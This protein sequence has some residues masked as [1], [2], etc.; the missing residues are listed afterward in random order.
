[1]LHDKESAG[2]RMSSPTTPTLTSTT[3]DQTTSLDPRRRRKTVS[4][5]QPST[6][7]SQSH[8]IVESAH[9]SRRSTMDLPSRTRYPAWVHQIEPAS[10]AVGSD[11]P[12]GHYLIKSKSSGRLRSAALERRLTISG[13]PHP[14]DTGKAGALTFAGTTPSTAPLP[15][16]SLSPSRSIPPTSSPSSPSRLHQPGSLSPIPRLP[17]SRFSFEVQSPLRKI[18]LTSHLK[19]ASID[20]STP[21]PES[22]RSPRHS[23]LYNGHRRSVPDFHSSHLDTESVSDPPVVSSAATATGQGGSSA[24]LNGGSTLSVQSPN[25]PKRRKST[26]Y[27]QQSPPDVKRRM[28][29][30]TATF[31]QGR[32]YADENGAA[33]KT[34]ESRSRNDDIFLNIARSDSSRRESLGRSELRRSR[35]RMSGTGFRSSTSRVSSDLT[36]SPEQLSRS[37]TFESPLHSNSQNGFPSTR[38]SSLPYSYSASAHPLD[39]S[40]RSPQSNF[41]SSSHSTVGLPRSRLSRTN[42]ED[43]P[44]SER[45]ASLHDSR[46]FR[47]S[48][49]STIRSSRQASAS[50]VTEKPRYESRQD[51][52]ESTLSTTAPSTVWDELEDLKSRI[53]KLELTGKLP[54]SSQEAMLSSGDRP[55][56]ATTTVTTMSSSPRHRRTS[57]SGESDTITAPNPVHPLL[58]SALVKVRSVVNKDVYTALEAAATD[59]MALSQILGAGKTPSGNVSIVNGYGSAER[60]SRRKADSVCRSLTELCLA[61]SDEHHTK[62]QSSGDTTFRISQSNTTDE[63]TVTPTTLSYRKSITQDHE[64]NAPRHSSGP[65]TA[66]RLEARRASLANQGDH[67]PSPENAG[68]STKLAHSP[69]APVTPATASR[70]SRLSV[71]MRT[72]RL[73]EDEPSD[74]R[75]PHTRSV[76]RSMTDIGA[77]SSTQKASPRQQS[78]FGYQAPRPI[79]DSQQSSQP[80]TP[81]SSQSG[82]PLR[83]SLM[84]PSHYTPAIPRANIQAGSRRY[85]LPSAAGSPVD[86]VPLSPRQDAP[87]S[88]ISAPSSKLA[89]SYTPIT[90][91]RLRANS[92]G[93]RRLGVRRP[94]STVDTKQ[95][96]SFNDSID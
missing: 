48:G 4:I 13:D 59:A 70:L 37:N 57:V 96:K 49:L 7:A 36:P 38:H 24:L 29:S 54:P 93:G 84:T 23:S 25:A 35:L 2:T 41:A 79:S 40:G 18:A 83:R 78:S 27:S 44:I 32:S 62:Q 81:T 1:M 33:A 68:Q 69:S 9:F 14:R 10:P 45:R 72:K 11:D 82:I 76:S 90:Q 75:S 53:K 73:Q 87:Q 80:R 34:D 77:A 52:T 31:V 74:Y 86:D 91:N 65:R 67:Y 6:H 64:G 28:P 60:Q 16:P 55:R 8:S 26:L 17:Q 12:E 39:E 19:T 85:G 42:P 94:M 71:S 66:S 21:A 15:S 92:L 88:R 56:T 61:L 46:S 63:G 3:K 30:S 22:S 47:H 5:V 89:S 58:Q 51:G 43:E 50:E 20:R 95:S